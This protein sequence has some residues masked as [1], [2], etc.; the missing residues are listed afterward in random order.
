MTSLLV[1]I[2]QPRVLNDRFTGHFY[3]GLNSS[4]EEK[5]SLSNCVNPNH[6]VLSLFVGQNKGFAKSEVRK[7]CAVVD[8]TSQLTRGK[9]TFEGA[10]FR[11]L[12]T[13][14]MCIRLQTATG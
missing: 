5:Y 11:Y 9:E 2:M 10:K 12:L 14:K 7:N 6:S 13:Q 1:S 8:T 4:L 3:R